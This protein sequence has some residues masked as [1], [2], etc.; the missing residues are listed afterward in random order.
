MF[1]EAE[2]RGSQEAQEEERV[3]SVEAPRLHCGTSEQ[4]EWTGAEKKRDKERGRRTTY[5]C[6]PSRVI[7]SSESVRNAS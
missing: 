2:T 3:L 1:L 5:N 6:H 7:L 4:R